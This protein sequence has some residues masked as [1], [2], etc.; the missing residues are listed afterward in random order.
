[1]SQST[2]LLVL[3]ILVTLIGCTS[4]S[5]QVGAGESCVK[6]EN[7]ISYRCVSGI[8]AKSKVNENCRQDSDCIDGSYCKNG[9]CFAPSPLFSWCLLV[10]GAGWLFN[11]FGLILLIIAIGG[12]FMGIS[13][14]GSYVSHMG[15]GVS[16]GGLL[17]FFVVA[18]ILFLFGL[19]LIPNFC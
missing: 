18:F 19:Y 16:F 12:F 2:M 3:L 10:H 1:M 11:L 15:S 9:K 6:D 8:C 7:C 17:A 4:Y 5:Y 13:G 14:G